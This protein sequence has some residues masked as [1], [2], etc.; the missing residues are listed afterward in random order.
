MIHSKVPT[1]DSIVP[2]GTPASLKSISKNSKR[3]RAGALHGGVRIF[4]P[5]RR[6]GEVVVQERV[7]GLLRDLARPQELCLRRRQA[8]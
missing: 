3:E 2:A 5:V 6:G 1:I 8:V 4:R 7:D